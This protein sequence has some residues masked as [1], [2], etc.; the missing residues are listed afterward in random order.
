MSDDVIQFPNAATPEQRA[1][2]AVALSALE[3][4][5]E[6]WCKDANVAG[7][8]KNIASV[9]RLNRNVP[10]DI[11]EQFIAR[12]ENLIAAMIEQAWIEGALRGTEGAFDAVRAG[13]VPK[14][15]SK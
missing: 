14:P 10:D 9:G 3:T 12:Q 2:C 4:L 13:Y 11:R 5:A 6:Q 8:A 15:T 7:I 1:E